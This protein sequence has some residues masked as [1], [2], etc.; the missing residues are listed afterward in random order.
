MARAPGVLTKTRPMLVF[1]G[2]VTTAF[3][4][5]AIVSWFTRHEEH[6]VRP[7][8]SAQFDVSRTNL[9]NSPR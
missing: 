1:L 7:V 3:V 5:S 2:G 8:S 4:L 6:S 9:R